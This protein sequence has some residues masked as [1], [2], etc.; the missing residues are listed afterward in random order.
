LIPGRANPFVILI[1]SSVMSFG[2][3]ATA[4]GYADAHVLHHAPVFV[5]EEAVQHEVADVAFIS[6]TDDDFV[7]CGV[8]FC[9]RL[10]MSSHQ[11]TVRAATSFVKAGDG[12]R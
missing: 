2:Y 8:L 6:G 11:A 3:T 12:R 10:K 5:V 7:G 1:A 9:K 4:V